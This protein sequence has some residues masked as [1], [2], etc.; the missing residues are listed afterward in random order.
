MARDRCGEEFVHRLMSGE[1]RRVIACALRASLRAAEPFYASAMRLRNRMFD[2]GWLAAH[3][4]GR[5]TISVGNVTAGG[6]GKTPF[7][8]WLAARLGD[9]GRVPAILLR[10]YQSIGGFSDEAAMLRA[11]LDCIVACGA[12]RVESATRV[13]KEHPEI[14]VFILDDAF[15]HRRAAR[16]L[17]IVLINAVQPFGYGHVHP[18]GLLR[19]PPAGLARAD[20]FVLTHADEVDDRSALRQEIRKHNATAP[21][22]AARHA[23]IGLR[24]AARGATAPPD[25]SLDE[26]SRRRIFVA[27]GIGSPESL[28]KQLEASHANLAGSRVLP[29]HHAFTEAD[30]DA[31]LDAARRAGADAIVVT[32]KDWAKIARLPA[33]KIAS[34]P[35]FLRLDMEIQ[36]L[37][38]ADEQAMLN[39]VRAALKSSREAAAEAAAMAAR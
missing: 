2:R 25:V 24:S 8:R 11:Q 1:D 20:A 26:L 36:F 21:I 38:A 4:L 10:G 16:D 15:Q 34:E 6:T 19:E 12:D 30:I 14:G 13:L 18:R 3:R 39:Q 5:P 28:L 29:D 31:L 17:D 27:C 32:E 22:Y 37:D 35:E 23:L 33:A 7:V 9:D